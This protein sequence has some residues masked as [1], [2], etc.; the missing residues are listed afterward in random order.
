MF[1]SAR[2]EAE[3]RKQ[4]DALVEK[5]LPKSVKGR[6]ATAILKMASPASNDHDVAMRLRLYER[7]WHFYEHMASRVP[8]RVPEWLGSVKDQATGLHTEGVLL[9]DLE[10]PGFSPG[11]KSGHSA[12]DS[13]HGTPASRARSM[14]RH[15]PCQPPRTLCAIASP[16]MV[17]GRRACLFAAQARPCA[18]SS[19]TLAF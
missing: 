5:E 4:G 15:E 17:M 9:E 19:T 12:S 6:P 13:R 14:K 10:I 18:R 2:K 11:G 3:A 16:V 8:V 7:E 1:A